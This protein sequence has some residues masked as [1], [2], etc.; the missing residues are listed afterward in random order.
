MKNILVAV[1]D[2]GEAEKLI[3]HAVKIAKLSADK[4]WIIHVTEFNPDNFLAREA[5]P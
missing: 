4:I 1:D 5:G 3:A 2:P